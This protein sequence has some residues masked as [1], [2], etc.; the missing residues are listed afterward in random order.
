[1]VFNDVDPIKLILIEQRNKRE[2]GDRRPA[3][4]V[5]SAIVIQYR[6]VK[7][8]GDNPGGLFML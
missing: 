2:R 6:S 5:V 3:N 4:V 8:G 1:M 7:P